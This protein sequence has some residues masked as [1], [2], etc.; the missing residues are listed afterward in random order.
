MEKPEGCEGCNKWSEYYDECYYCKTGFI[1]IPGCPCK[2][3][4]VKISCVVIY[5]CHIFIKYRN[6]HWAF[7]NLKELY[8]K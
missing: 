3:C 6:K 4:L 2:E 5:D 7:P 8:G 1:E